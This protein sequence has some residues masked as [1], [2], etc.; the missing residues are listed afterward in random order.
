MFYT[1]LVFCDPLDQSG[2]AVQQS[3]SPVVALFEGPKRAIKA[4]VGVGGHGRRRAGRR[5]R[6]R[7]RLPARKQLLCCKAHPMGITMHQ[8]LYANGTIS[9]VPKPK[10]VVFWDLARAKAEAGRSV[11]RM[12]YVPH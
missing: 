11:Q 7:A 12:R 9:P 2:A 4:R 6:F 5:A 1:P 10:R 8:L 3:S